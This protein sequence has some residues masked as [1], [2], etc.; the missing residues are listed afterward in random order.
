MASPRE[1]E[2]TETFRDGDVTLHIGQE[3]LAGHV[4]ADR[5]LFYFG[6]YG[7]CALRLPGGAIEGRER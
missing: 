1:G 5:V 2:E 3:V 7:H 6:M 4:K